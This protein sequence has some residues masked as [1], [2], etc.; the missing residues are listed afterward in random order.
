M[1]AI[2]PSD[3]TGAPVTSPQAASYKGDKT[4]IM[5]GHKYSE[6]GRECH[7]PECSPSSP[8]DSFTSYKQLRKSV[9]SRSSRSRRALNRTASR[10]V[11][12]VRRLSRK[13]SRN[14][15]ELYDLTMALPNIPPTCQTLPMCENGPVSLNRAH[16][17]MSDMTDMTEA[18]ILGQQ[19]LRVQT[20]LCGFSPCDGKS[21]RCLE[22]SIR[23][24]SPCPT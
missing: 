24:R 19:L 8:T 4:V 18:E 11:D 1:L 17:D 21:L 9:R 12:L 14:L 16:T 7:S 13:H 22:A 2:H 10:G 15:K 3:I 6:Y 5:S 20:C 23:A